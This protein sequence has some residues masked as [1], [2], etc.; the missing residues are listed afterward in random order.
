M[1]F[2]EETTSPTSDLPCL[3]VEQQTSC[4]KMT[5]KLVKYVNLGECSPDIVKR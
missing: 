1:T 2:G 4:S 3:K 5:N